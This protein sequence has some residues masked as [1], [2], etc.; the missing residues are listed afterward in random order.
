MVLRAADFLG[1]DVSKVVVK[2]WRARESNKIA[3]SRGT[4]SAGTKVLSARFL[5]RTVSSEGNARPQETYMVARE[6]EFTWS[7][8]IFW[9]NNRLFFAVPLVLEIFCG[10]WDWNKVA[11]STPT[12]WRLFSYG[13]SILSASL[14]CGV[15]FKA[16]HLVRSVGAH[17]GVQKGSLSACTI[18]TYLLR[19]PNYLHFLKLEWVFFPSG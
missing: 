19:V 12:P 14:S 17:C 2:E 4:L 8:E 10:A 1:V 13:P 15:W 5:S 6:R 18:I 11:R 7:L 9:N 16:R 3:T